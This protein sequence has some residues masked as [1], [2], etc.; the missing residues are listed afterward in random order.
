VASATPGA[1]RGTTA[2]SARIRARAALSVALASVANPA[3]VEPAMPT[4]TRIGAAVA[5][6]R[7]TAVRAP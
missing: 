4:V 7:R 1:A 6:V 3:R 2:A 5:A